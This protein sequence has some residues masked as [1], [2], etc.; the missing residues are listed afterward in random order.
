MINSRGEDPH[1][2][3]VRSKKKKKK[4]TPNYLSRVPLIHSLTIHST[5]D[6]VFHLIGRCCYRLVCSR[7]VESSESNCR[8]VYI[9]YW[10]S[11]C[12]QQSITRFVTRVCNNTLPGAILMYFK[13]GIV[14]SLC[15]LH[16]SSVWYCC[17]FNCLHTRSSYRQSALLS[18]S[19][20]TNSMEQ[21]PFWEANRSSAGQ[22]THCFLWNT[23]VH[24]RIHK[25]TSP[26]LILSQNNPVLASPSHFLKIHLNII[27]PSTPRSSKWSLSISSPHQN[28]IC[29]RT[30]PV[31]L[32]CHMPRTFYSSWLDHM[33]NNWWRVQIV[34]PLVM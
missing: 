11:L 15:Y 33:N 5:T 19:G 29:T 32:S 21:S 34:K 25:R 24:Y 3:V 13:L 1:W 2:T 12:L 31:P 27:L 18:S 20:Y 10:N 7:S 6:R 26:V 9:K 8:Q 30:F 14:T 4:K 22:G 23:K 16:S 17:F 28:P